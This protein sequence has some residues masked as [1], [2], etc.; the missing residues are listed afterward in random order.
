MNVLLFLQEED[1]IGDDLVTGVQT[2]ALPICLMI[3]APGIGTA[4]NCPTDYS[5][6]NA[7]VAAYSGVAVGLVSVSNTQVIFEGDVDGDGVVDSVPYPLLD[8]AGHYPPPR[9]R[10]PTTTPPHM[11]KR[12]HPLTLP[13]SP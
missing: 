3:R 6:T 13:H 9:T 12:Q 10:P 2:C 5:I 11:P 7:N 8:S 4:P 1:G